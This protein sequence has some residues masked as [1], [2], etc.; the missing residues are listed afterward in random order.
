[1]P[2]LFCCV[3]CMHVIWNSLFRKT[4]RVTY[5]RCWLELAWD[6]PVERG[7]TK[8]EGRFIHVC[9]A[10]TFDCRNHQTH[11][12]IVILSNYLQLR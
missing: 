4:G 11:S 5:I 8:K 2:L 10:F 9:A 12:Y 7:I 3:L 6:L 1:M